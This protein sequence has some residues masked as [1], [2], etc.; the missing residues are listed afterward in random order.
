MS[1]NWNEVWDSEGVTNGFGDRRQKPKTA[2]DVPASEGGE[3]DMF[4]PAGVAAE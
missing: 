3:G 1:G 4:S 2:N